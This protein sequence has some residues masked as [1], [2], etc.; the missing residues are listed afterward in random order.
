MVMAELVGNAVDHGL[1]GLNSSLKSTPEGFTEYYQQRAQ[2]LAGLTEGRLLIRCSLATHD[3]GGT[4]M[5]RVEDSGPGFD[6]RRGVPELNHNAGYSG[7]GI[8]LVRS[9]CRE[10]R[11]SDKGNV[12][13][14]VYE[15]RGVTRR[16]D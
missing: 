10:V 15:G 14:A 1:L 7:R 12:V 3:S 9:L 4:L 2:A 5:I 13:E 6:A 8:P 11:F 16:G